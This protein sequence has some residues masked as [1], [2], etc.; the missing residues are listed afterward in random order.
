MFTIKS[1]LL[2]FGFLYV[3]TR[4]KEQIIEVFFGMPGSLQL[5]LLPDV[6]EIDLFSL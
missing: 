5:S 2:F 6:K 1:L 4:H 3:V